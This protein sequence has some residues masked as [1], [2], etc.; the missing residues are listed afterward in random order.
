MLILSI[1]MVLLLK[2]GNIVM[3]SDDK[4][5]FLTEA[6]WQFMGRPGKKGALGEFIDS[7]N[8]L[9]L[10][11]PALKELNENLTNFNDLMKRDIELRRRE[12]AIKLFEMERYGIKEKQI[13]ATALRLEKKGL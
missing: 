9:T 10:N 7:V 11:A 8:Q 4:M 6:L 12:Y 3:Y 1:I 13:E 5:A 2:E